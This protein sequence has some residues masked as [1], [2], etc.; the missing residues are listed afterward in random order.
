[1]SRSKTLLAVSAAALLA[2]TA[3]V[4]QAQVAQAQ[5]KPAAKPWYENVKLSGLAFGDAYAVADH[6]S[7][8]IEDQNGFWIRRAYLTFDYAVEDKWSARFRLEANSPGDFVTN[9]RL[10]P[11]VKDAYIAWKDRG[12]ELYLGI[13][14]SPT[15]DV[16]ENFWGYRAIEKTPMDLYRLGSSRD[17]GIAY[18][19]KTAGGKISYHAMYGNG[20]GEGAETNEGKK[21]MLSVAFRPTEKVVFELGGDFENRPGQTDR[22]TFQAFLGLKGNK[23]RAGLHYMTQDRDVPGGAT[24]NLAVASAFGVFDL[25]EKYSLLLRYDRCFDPNPEADRIPYLVLARNFELDL[26]VVGVEYRLGKK[27]SLT[28]NI[29]FVTYSDNGAIAAPDDDVFGKLTLYFQF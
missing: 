8:T 13:S 2:L 19:G 24:F 3:T 16:V 17:F 5:D 27:I 25:S 15:F 22:T 11:F 18:K 14:P 7:P 9:T 6:H 12:R 4:A 29:E 20:S 23:G 21:A 28:P 26:A 1:M 10:D